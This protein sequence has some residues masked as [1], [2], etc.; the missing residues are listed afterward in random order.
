MTVILD[1]SD[2]PWDEPEPPHHHPHVQT[3][4]VAHGE[5]MFYC[6]DEP[7]AHL[8]AGDLFYVPSGKAHSIKL[9]TKTARLIDNFNPIREDFLI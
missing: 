9:L 6:E 2:G 8:Q 1:F 3:C 5:I 7:E 4:Y